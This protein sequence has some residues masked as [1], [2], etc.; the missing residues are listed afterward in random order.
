[1][2]YVQLTNGFGNNLFQSIAGK[3]LSEHNKDQLFLIEPFENYYGK[4]PLQQLGFEFANWERP[5][6]PDR[7]IKEGQYVSAF[8]IKTV[9]SIVLLSGYFED[10]RYYL[11]NRQKIKD[12]F[13][14]IEKRNVDDLVLHIRG[15][16][17]L[18]YKSTFDYKPSPQQYLSALQKFDFEKLYIVSDM[19]KW[20]YITEEELQNIKFHVDVAAIDRVPLEDSVKYFNSLVAGLSTYSPIFERKTIIGDF[21]FIRS[22]DNILFE[23][24]TLSWWA[25][26]LSDAKKVGVYGPWRPWKGKSNKNL[27]Q[28]PLDG[29]FQW[30]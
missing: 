7:I 22:C 17:R 27:S 2:I 1:M 15:G 21:N 3:I 25:A 16:D 6:K 24:G 11:N 23:N 20:D 13:P 12:W 26:F 28:A 14:K 10:Y 19:P 30:G 8:D 4:P 9:G 29:W 18:F 5:I